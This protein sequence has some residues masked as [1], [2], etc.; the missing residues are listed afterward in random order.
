[1][2]GPRLGAARA[3][4]LADRFSALT[5]LVV[6]DVMLDRFIVGHVT[7]ISP[8]AP[9][10]VVRFQSEHVRAGGA[11]N[12]AQN[13]AA[14]GGGAALVGVVGTDSTAGKLRQQLEAAGVGVD[15]LIEDPA[16]RTTEKVRVVTERN[17][18]VARID[19]EEDGDVAAPAEQALVAAIARLGRRADALLVSDYLKGAVTRPIVESLVAAAATR[20]AGG[21]ATPL[22][23]DP[24]IPHLACYAGATLVTPNHHEAEAATHRRIRT[25]AEARD[26]GREFRRQAACGAALIT[27][28]EQGMW[29]SSEEAEEAIPAV[30][31]EVADVTGAGDTVV[32]MLALALAAGA[33][34]LEAA[35]LANHAA[36]V[37]VGKFG[38]ATLSRDELLRSFD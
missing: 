9:V 13:I 4:Q 27:R 6:G 19:Y 24:K 32:A 2:S 12:V 21:P 11:A 26:A 10:P 15:G 29:L 23:I 22:I 38:A 1:M 34:L 28:G 7:R 8:E 5:V 37:V 36:G 3:R 25:D 16:R 30:A 17:Q 33:T 14:L 20:S 31:R 18:Q 35:V